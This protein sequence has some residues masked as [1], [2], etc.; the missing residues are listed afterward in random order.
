MIEA[1]LEVVTAAEVNIVVEEGVS[2]A[3]LVV[4]EEAGPW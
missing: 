3:V 1:V 2:E 4:Q